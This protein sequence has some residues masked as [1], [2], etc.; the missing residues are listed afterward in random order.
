MKLQASPPKPNAFDCE[1]KA[2]AY[3][4]VLAANVARD[5]FRKKNA[6]KR[7]GAKTTPVED[8]F[9][10]IAGSGAPNLERNVLIRQ[11]DCLLEGD[12]EGRSIF[13]L[14]YQ[15]GLTAKEISALPAF[16]LSPKGVESLLRRLTLRIRGHFNGPEGFSEPEAF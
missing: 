14:Y 16:H 3:L 4:K 15:Q 6:D 2:T 10:E 5:Y 13:W 8:R 1:Q 9:Q 12:V 7:G 11:I